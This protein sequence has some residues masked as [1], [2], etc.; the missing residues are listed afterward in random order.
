[1][2]RSIWVETVAVIEDQ[3]RSVPAREELR[4]R[5]HRLMG[6]KDLPDDPNLIFYLAVLALVQSG[7]RD[8]RRVAAVR[9]WLIRETVA[10]EACG[11]DVADFRHDCKSWVIRNH[12]PCFLAYQKGHYGCAK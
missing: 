4:L 12:W 10:V 1:M 5:A 9:R 2:S 6:S 3:I 11:W 8:A 7:Q